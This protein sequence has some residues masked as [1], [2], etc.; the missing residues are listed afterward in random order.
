LSAAKANARYQK[1]E[2]SSTLKKVRF[3]AIYINA[4]PQ[5]REAFNNLQ[6]DE[7][8]LVPIQDVRT[9]WN[10]TF[11]I[12]RRAKRL[13]P[14]FAPFCADYNCEEMLLS[15]EEWRQVDYLL[16]ITEPFFLYTTEL[17]KTRDVTSH[18][19]FKI[20]NVLFDHLE[21]SISQLQ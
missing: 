11:L 5:R 9:Q 8:K 20:Y 7:P 1:Y 21:K 14:V 3:L 16:C 15:I 13:R 19:V 6:L 4:S 10:S 18:L 2:I 17:S 12:L